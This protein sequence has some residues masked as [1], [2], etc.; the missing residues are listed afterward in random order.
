MIYDVTDKRASYRETTIFDLQAAFVFPVRA[1]L[2]R[3]FVRHAI[4]LW[5]WREHGLTL[6]GLKPTLQSISVAKWTYCLCAVRFE[7]CPNAVL[8]DVVKCIKMD[9]NVFRSTCVYMSNKHHPILT[10][11]LLQ[12]RNFVQIC[13]CDKTQAK[14]LSSTAFL[15]IKIVCFCQHA[16]VWCYFNSFLKCKTCSKGRWRKSHRMNQ[17]KI[18]FRQTGPATNSNNKTTANGIS[19]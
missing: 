2:Q 14:N 11:A 16:G 3:R 19:V 15:C 10:M 18:S 5:P 7:M 6:T 13:H 12:L 8:V 9:Y 1:E 17:Q 4:G